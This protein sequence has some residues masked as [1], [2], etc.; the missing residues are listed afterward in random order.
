M[1]NSFTNAIAPGSPE[2]ME[3]PAP[4]QTAKEPLFNYLISQF[5]EIHNFLSELNLVIT[6]HTRPAVAEVVPII[7]MIKLGLLTKFS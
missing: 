2:G 3:I 4:H 5:I 1:R 7:V 6:S